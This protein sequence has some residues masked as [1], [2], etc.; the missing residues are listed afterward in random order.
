M[1]HSLW[2]EGTD[3]CVE[4]FVWSVIVSI[5]DENLAAPHH[6]PLSQGKGEK[7]GKEQAMVKLG[8]S[9]SCEAL[10]PIWPTEP[11]IIICHYSF[12]FPPEF[13]F[14]KYI[15][16]SPVC[17]LLVLFVFCLPSL[18]GWQKQGKYTTTMA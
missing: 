10:Q 1:D 16:S 9:C 14:F 2:R 5:I 3:Q 12:P 4:K 8:S 17:S 11:G 15:I 6:K 18:Q 7:K 13:Y